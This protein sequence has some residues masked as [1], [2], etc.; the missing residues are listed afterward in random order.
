M[1]VSLGFHFVKVLFILHAIT[2]HHR[3]FLHEGQNR[4]DRLL[5]LQHATAVAS[6][7]F[8]VLLLRDA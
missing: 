6:R 5:Q 1:L 2:L 7:G 8:Q 3:S 4:K